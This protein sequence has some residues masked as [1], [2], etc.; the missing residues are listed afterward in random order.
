MSNKLMLVALTV[1]SAMMLIL[2][3]AASAWSIDPAGV[4]LTGTG[5]TAKMSA[6]GEPTITCEGPNHITASFNPGST[7]TGKYHI[8]YTNCHIVVLGFTI[9]CHTEGSE[10]D[11]TITESGTFHLVPIISGPL[12][13]FRMARDATAVR[14]TRC[15]STKPITVG[16]NVIGEVTSP[17]SCPATQET[18]TVNFAVEG[19]KQKIKTIAGEAA[20]Y[21]L[22]ATTEGGSAVEAALEAEFTLEFAENATIT[23]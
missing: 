7:I 23:C 10:K 22:T 19:G 5:N 2:P 15:G 21:N 1:I 16:G 13:G 20:E 6:P 12:R 17:V 4:N 14:T 11:N 3:A 9:K 18:M 8:D